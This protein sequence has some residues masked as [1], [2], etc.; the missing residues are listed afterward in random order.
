MSQFSLSFGSDCMDRC[1]LKEG[2]M[3]REVSIFGLWILQLISQH[4]QVF[5]M[6]MV[7]ATQGD[8]CHVVP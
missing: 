2:F 8:F 4:S 7:D 5:I 1:L 6:V 3:M